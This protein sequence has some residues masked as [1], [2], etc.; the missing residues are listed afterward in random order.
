MTGAVSHSWPHT[1]PLTT[2]HTGEHQANIYCLSAHLVREEMINFLD[3]P[4][5]L[6]H[7]DYKTYYMDMSL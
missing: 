4:C 3:F 1:A 5:L 6:P 2:H 7:G